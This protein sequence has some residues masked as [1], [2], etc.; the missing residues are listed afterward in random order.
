MRFRGIACSPEVEEKLLRKHHVGL[1]DV[2]EALLGDP[3]I[4]RGSGGLRYVLSQTEAGRYL[5]IVV[6]YLGAGVARIVTA[7]DMN[8]AER[9]TYWRR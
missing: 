7:R 8:D 5:A 4:V 6:R 1:D 9:R 2:R 3:H